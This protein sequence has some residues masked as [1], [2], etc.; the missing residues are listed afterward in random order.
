MMYQ[1]SIWIKKKIQELPTPEKVLDIGS[2]TSEFRK[3]FQDYIDKNIFEY[4]RKKNAEIQYLDMKA[5]KGIDV[6]ADISS[7]NFFLKEQFDLVLCCSLLEHVNDMETTIK[8]ISSTVSKGGYLIV[9]IPYRH[10]YHLDPIDTLRRYSPIELRNLFP[11]FELIASDIINAN[12]GLV[13]RTWNQA[14][15]TIK[16]FKT[17]NLP[18]LK[19]NIFLCLFRDSQVSCVLLRKK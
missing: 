17:R 5:G 11:E 8:N 6:V 7:E 15:S 1:E 9:T 13:P 10:Q 3:V 18:A 14:K 12:I 19:Y 16:A 4:L 2:S